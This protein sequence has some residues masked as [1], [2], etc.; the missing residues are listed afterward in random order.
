MKLIKTLAMRFAFNRSLIKG[1]DNFYSILVEV[2]IFRE[3]R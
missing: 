1:T 2:F 3:R